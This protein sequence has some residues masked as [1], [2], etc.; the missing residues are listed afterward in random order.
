VT[1]SPLSQPALLAC[2]RASYRASYDS[3]WV[4]WHTPIY[5]VFEL[6]LGWIDVHTTLGIAPYVLTL[7]TRS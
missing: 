5:E 7:L 6:Y 2:K 4:E 1:I 3:M